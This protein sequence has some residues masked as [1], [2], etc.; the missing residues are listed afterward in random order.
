MALNQSFI[1]KIYPAT[2]PYEVGREKIREFATAI[3]DFN[4]AYHDPVIAQSLG[5]R[6]V[7]APPTFA[8]TIGIGALGTVMF[9]PEL[10]LD[11]SRVV[12]GEERFAFQR[13]VTAGDSLLVVT[14]I[15]AVR[16]AAGNDILTTRFDISTEDGELVVTTWAVTVARGITEESA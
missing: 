11:F 12:H 9:D 1:G 8:F 7:I 15:E 4:P 5:Y 13:P 2:A 10:G 16:L 3:G 6:D 14:T